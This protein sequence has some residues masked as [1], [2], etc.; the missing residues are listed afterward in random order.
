[1]GAGLS[2]S[3]GKLRR[4]DNNIYFDCYDEDGKVTQTKILP[5]NAIDEIYLLARVEVD[6]Y[7]IAFL[8]D[9]NILLHFFSPYQSFRGNFYPN[10]PNSV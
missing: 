6:S 10:T 9:N 7:T 5:I 3:P 1:M 8:A 4:K 2:H